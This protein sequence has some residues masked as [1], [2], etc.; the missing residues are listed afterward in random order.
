MYASYPR[1]YS[2]DM[3]LLDQ[4][5]VNPKFNLKL[6]FFLTEA[7]VTYI[8]QCTS[9]YDFILSSHNIGAVRL[10]FSTTSLATGTKRSLIPYRQAYDALIL[11]ELVHKSSNQSLSVYL[12]THTTSVVG[13]FVSCISEWCKYYSNDRLP[14]QQQ[15]YSSVYRRRTGGGWWPTQL[16]NF[17]SAN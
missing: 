7:R 16:Q 13:V 14:Q 17:I 8:A 6:R 15:A 4:I 3:T 10:T 1:D 9:F 12:W 2:V 11:L 5:S